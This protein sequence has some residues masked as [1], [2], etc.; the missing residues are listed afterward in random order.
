MWAES[1]SLMKK[2]QTFILLSWKLNA[3][4]MESVGF[5]LNLIWLPHFFWDAVFL[6]DVISNRVKGKNT[7][8]ISGEFI[9]D[10]DKMCL[11]VCDCVR[12][13][14]RVSV[15]V[16]VHLSF[17][18][19]WFAHYII[20]WR[21]IRSIALFEITWVPSE[22]VSDYTPILLKEKWSQTRF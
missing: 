5:A 9:V 10:R 2:L 13:R 11:H 18:R 15:S 17:C 16:S 8:L 1:L 19:N 12:A 4:W 22:T 14:V 7:R 6:W 20:R 3:P 21:H